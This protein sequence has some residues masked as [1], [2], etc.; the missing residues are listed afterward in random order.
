MGIINALE[1]VLHFASKMIVLKLKGEEPDK[2]EIEEIKKHCE[3][4]KEANVFDFNTEDEDMLLKQI[5]EF[6]SKV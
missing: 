1:E 3:L 2:T 6:A 4:L 5:Q